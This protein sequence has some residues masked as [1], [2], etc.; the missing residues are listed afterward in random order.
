[1]KI[2]EDVIAA[3]AEGELERVGHLAAELEILAGMARRGKRIAAEISQRRPAGMFF[4][5]VFSGG[6]LWK[7]SD[8][9]GRRIDSTAGTRRCPR[10]RKNKVWQRPAVIPSGDEAAEGNEPKRGPRE[11]HAGNG[12]FQNRA[13][14][15]IG[16]AA[17]EQ[18]ASGRAADT[19]R[20][21]HAVASKTRHGM[22][23]CGKKSD[24]GNELEPSTD[25]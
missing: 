23:S 8:G 5:H 12:S 19:H 11:S 24:G 3:V 4:G 1:M 7:R 18:R 9:S 22:A 13:D 10:P 21:G 2:A 16:S 6:F 25:H 14:A 20:K 15:R 17:R